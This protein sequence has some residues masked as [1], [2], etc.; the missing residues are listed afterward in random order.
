[1]VRT[2]WSDAVS[3]LCAQGFTVTVKRDCRPTGVGSDYA[4][5]VLER[6]TR[7]SSWKTSTR[8]TEEAGRIPPGVGV[9]VVVAT[10]RPC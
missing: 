10:G 8:C 3:N 1:M 2:Y 4:I 7:R 6:T 5:R 9:I